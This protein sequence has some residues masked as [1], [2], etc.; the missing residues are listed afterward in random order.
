MA[1]KPAKR[2]Q[3]KRGARRKSTRNKRRMAALNPA[4]A[5][6]AQ[7]D[8]V[9][10]E[11]LFGEVLERHP[12]MTEA[13]GA[14]AELLIQ[15]Q[16]LA[17]AEQVLRHAIDLCSDTMQLRM[18]L[19][20]MYRRF[21][22]VQQAIR[23]FS[24]CVAL[25]ADHVEARFQLG[26]AHLGALQVERGVEHLEATL[27]LDP[28]HTEAQL[29]LGQALHVLRRS[30]EAESTLRE[31]LRNDPANAS[32]WQGLGQVLMRKGEMAEAHSCF[33]QVLKLN[34]ALPD[35]STALAR[36]RRYTDADAEEVDELTRLA[37]ESSRWP[38][39][40]ADYQFALGKIMDDLGRYDEA[41][42]YYSEGNK[43]ARSQRQPFD[44]RS[45]TQ[46]VDRMIDTFSQA[47]YKHRPEHGDPSTLP[48]FVV[49]MERSGTTLVEQ[50]LASHPAVFGADELSNITELAK[51]VKSK[52]GADVSYPRC[53]VDI[54]RQLSRSLGAEYVSQ[55]RELSADA[56][57]V[58]DKMPGNIFH[59]GLIAL[60]LPNAKIVHCRREPLDVALSIFFQ[61]FENGHEWA[62]SLEEI[63][64]YY[65]QYDRVARHWQSAL[66]MSTCEVSY[67]RLVGN[68]EQV[69]RELIEYCGLPWDDACLSYHETDR[70]V[71]SASNWQVRQPIY[72]HSVSR[73]RNYEPHLG[74]LARE[75]GRLDPRAPRID[76]AS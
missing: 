65:K 15:C 72:K 16:R 70:L 29:R 53:A 51:S 48:V 2:N 34:P 5:A 27:R 42:A 11:R 22:K 1:P 26:F 75:L 30:D 50:I 9:L 36:S 62:Y 18:Q 23:C 41:F 6:L 43:L 52:T 10:A 68:Q 17:E 58:V 33:A 56:E 54:G 32:G 35:A 13:H 40:R 25:D 66:P 55:I 31:L 73:W 24:E 59:L 67:E 28:A 63:A 44:M 19:G 57:R 3:K 39:V 61:Q 49:G 38:A 37:E 46:V 4:K 20:G 14:L 47:F 64:A 12:R 7:G 69:S 60:I 45:L 21:G 76:T 8:T 71:G 74:A